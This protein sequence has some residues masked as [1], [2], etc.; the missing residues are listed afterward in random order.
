MSRSLSSDESWAIA[1]LAFFYL[2]R[3]RI[4]E[5][6]ALARGLITLDQRNGLGWLYYGEA[7]QMQGDLNE[8]I[9][10]YQEAAKYMPENGEVWMRLGQALLRQGRVAEADR[11]LKM[12][13]SCTME[14]GVEARVKALLKRCRSRV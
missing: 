13:R 8:A 14:P 1:R 4:K 12:T 7:R 10:G 6:E 2:D 3:G 11:A 9:R 5:A